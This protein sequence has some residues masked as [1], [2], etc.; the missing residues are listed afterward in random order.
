MGKSLDDKELSKVN[1]GQ[2]GEGGKDF[3]ENVI[4]SAGFIGTSAEDHN[5]MLTSAPSEAT[6]APCCKYCHKPF[7]SVLLKEHEAQCPQKPAVNFK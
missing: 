4:L 6:P 3:Y 2:D 5:I 7:S 1:G